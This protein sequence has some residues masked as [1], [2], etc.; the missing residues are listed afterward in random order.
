MAVPGVAWAM[1]FEHLFFGHL[2]Y[3]S[4]INNLQNIISIVSFAFGLQ[5]KVFVMKII[6]I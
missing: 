5:C 6:Y 3:K 2:Q 4:S 1:T